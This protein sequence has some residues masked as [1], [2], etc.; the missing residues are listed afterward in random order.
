MGNANT[1]KR[2]RQNL[3]TDF[4]PLI[5]THNLGWCGGI[6]ETGLLQRAHTVLFF[7]SHTCVRCKGI[8]DPCCCCWALHF[9]LDYCQHSLCLPYGETEK[10]AFVPLCSACN[11]TEFSFVADGCQGVNVVLIS[12]CSAG[13]RAGFCSV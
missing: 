7:L 8:A 6:T 11:L 9:V 5:C 13:T 4:S 10:S 12:V 2:C 3:E 1:Y